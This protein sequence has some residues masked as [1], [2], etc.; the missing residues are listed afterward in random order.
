LAETTL[1][2]KDA[3]PEHHT[4]VFDA[5]AGDLE[6]ELENGDNDALQM[7]AWILSHSKEY[8]IF[9]V[10]DGLRLH[11]KPLSLYYGEVDLGKKAPQ[12]DIEK[13]AAEATQYAEFVLGEQREN[14]DYRRSW[15]DPP[16]SQWV[17]RGA[18]WISS[19]LLL[20]YTWRVY[21]K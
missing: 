8:L 3:K 19:L 17:F 5:T 18:F 13:S 4:L 2:R 6:L 1:E 20:W 15:W 10:P 16:A 11:K 9:P 12:Y 21:R 7:T 14:L